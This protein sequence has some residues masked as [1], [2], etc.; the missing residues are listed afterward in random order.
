MAG[1]AAQHA[2]ESDADRNLR[3]GQARRDAHLSNHVGESVGYG[4]RIARVAD[5]F[6]DFHDRFGSVGLAAASRPR[7]SLEQRRAQVRSAEIDADGDV[8]ARAPDE[9]PS[10]MGLSA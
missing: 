9:P 5:R 7:Q 10:G 8:A 3:D 6:A 2:G 1:V 4:V